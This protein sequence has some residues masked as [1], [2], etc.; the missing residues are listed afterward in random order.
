[1]ERRLGLI[2]PSRSGSQC[3]FCT[4]DRKTIVLKIRFYVVFEREKC[5]SASFS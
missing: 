5:T 1:M 4:L 3:Q 2:G